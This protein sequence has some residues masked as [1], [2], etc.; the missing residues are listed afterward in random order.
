MGFAGQRSR[1]T[2]PKAWIKHKVIYHTNL[3]R[4]YESAEE[5][6][7]NLVKKEGE[8]SR[9]KYFSEITT[10]ELNL[11]KGVKVQKAEKTR[12]MFYFIHFVFKII[13]SS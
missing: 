12:K 13:F 9:N 6:T 11:E 8:E 5:K 1:F 2:K 4:I 10:L 7:P 3:A